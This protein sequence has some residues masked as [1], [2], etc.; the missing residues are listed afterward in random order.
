M[1]A[2]ASML[3]WFPGDCYV[4]ACTSPTGALIFR[5][6]GNRMSKFGALGASGCQGGSN[7]AP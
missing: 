7:E 4:N 5:R 3:M 1:A 2:L 6:K